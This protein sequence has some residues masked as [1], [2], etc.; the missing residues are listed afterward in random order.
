[1]AGE[2]SSPSHGWAS[3]DEAV[4]SSRSPATPHGLSSTFPANL[5]DII[6]TPLAA[7]KAE[8]PASGSSVPATSATCSK[9]RGEGRDRGAFNKMSQEAKRGSVAL[10]LLLLA[11][12]D[13]AAA[14]ARQLLLF[15][16]VPN[17]P[18]I[19]AAATATAASSIKPSGGGGGGGKV[20]LWCG[21][22]EWSLAGRQVVLRLGQVR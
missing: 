7:I 3:D 16:V 4:S 20:G 19:L 17:V 13:T 10:V 6:C 15:P 8:A 1:M 2:D 21:I 11:A 9:E 22:G 12:A 14:A 5:D 18:A